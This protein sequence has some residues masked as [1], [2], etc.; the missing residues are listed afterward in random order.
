MRCIAALCAAAAAL[1]IAASFSAGPAAHP[2]VTAA[3]CYQRWTRPR[4]TN[5]SKREQSAW[6]RNIGGRG[7]GV[8]RRNAAEEGEGPVNMDDSD[9]PDDAEIYASLRKRL[10]ELEKSA[11]VSDTGNGVQPATTKAMAET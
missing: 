7:R 4:Q 9:D 1:P 11:P 8:V 3:S 5:S 2:S 10:E 6:R